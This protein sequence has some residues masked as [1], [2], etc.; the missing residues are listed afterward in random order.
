MTAP[1]GTSAD[2][3]PAARSPLA[4]VQRFLGWRRIAYAAGETSNALT[5]ALFVL[6]ARYLGVEPYGELVTIVAAGAILSTGVEFGFHTLL[7]RAI[8]RRPDTA[9]HELAGALRRQLL[10]GPFLLPL[11]YAYLTIA[12]F[13]PDGRVAGLLIGA[14]VVV[15]ALKETM[16]GTCRGLERFALEAL[17]LWTER[18]GLLAASAAAL[19]LGGGIV[20]V[21][22]IFLTVRLLDFGTFLLALRRRLPRPAGARPG[23]A[24]W[25]A[26][27]P[28]AIGNLLWSMYAQLDPALAAALATARDAGIYGAVYR[29][30]DLVQVLPRLLIVVTYPTMAV[31]WL[32]NP[33]RFR[34]G[35]G[36]LHDLLLLLGLPVLF[37]PIIAGEWLLRHG[38]GAAYA[39]GG[40]ALQI[41][42]VA[43]LF[44]F[45]SVLLV[46]ALQAAGG[47]RPLTAVLAVT[48]ALKVTLN[49]ALTPRWGYL[50]TALAAGATEL[51]YFA[52]L[53]IVLHRL[54]AGPARD[55][56]LRT[57]AGAGCLGAAAWLGAAGSTLGGTAA[58]V[59]GW[60]LLAARTRARALA[61]WKAL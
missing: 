48:V 13:S 17:F 47:E 21:G 30:T 38:F 14:S 41:L 1:P 7:T 18:G 5:L 12:G 42:M 39:T 49:L 15:R 51:G 4:W 45:Q 11:L 52:L 40:P 33:D 32:H 57:A 23:A 31:A 9:S 50:G 2:A 61:A 36:A 16:R 27:L 60:G 35:V 6:L 3:A 20:T 19:A 25:R 56:T 10:I 28:F 22:T 26:A 54:H 58:F 59:L 46:Q 37:V 53:T 55:V 43:G 34:Q 24:T 29:F 44:S 8:A